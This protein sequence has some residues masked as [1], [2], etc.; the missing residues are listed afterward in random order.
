M[1]VTVNRIGEQTYE[2]D[3]ETFTTPALIQW[4]VVCND[5][6][7]P[8]EGIYVPLEIMERDWARFGSEVKAKW[9]A[10]EVEYLQHLLATHGCHHTI[11]FKKMVLGVL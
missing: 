10:A 1:S 3:G 8:D 2:E 11:P 7:G 6:G 5:H 9:L 4:L